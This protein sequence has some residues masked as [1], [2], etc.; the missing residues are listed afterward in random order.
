MWHNFPAFTPDKN[1]LPMKNKSYFVVASILNG[2]P[3]VK[4]E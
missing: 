1:E 4:A 3:L 2:E